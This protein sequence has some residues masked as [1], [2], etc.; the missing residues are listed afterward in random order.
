MIL[1]IEW[2]RLCACDDKMAVRVLQVLAARALHGFL[3]TT[4]F[5]YEKVPAAESSRRY[6][7]LL[8]RGYRRRKYREGC[9]GRDTCQGRSW[10][11]R[12]YSHCD[13]SE[14]PS[15]PRQLIGG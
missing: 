1:L 7:L 11:R 9:V 5:A 8:E 14:C 13:Q 6:S 12:G 2:P 3:V 4:N 15:R 10:P